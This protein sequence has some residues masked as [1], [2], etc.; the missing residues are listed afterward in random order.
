M[1]NPGCRVD[2]RKITRCSERGAVLADL[3]SKAQFSE[4]LELGRAH[5]GELQA[6]PARVPAVLLEWIADPR[7]DDDLGHRLLADMANRGVSVLGY[8]S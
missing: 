3:L 1:P 6:E 7:P 4:C 5:G 2:I 8:G